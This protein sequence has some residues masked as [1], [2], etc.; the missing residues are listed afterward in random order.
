MG[1]LTTCTAS[2]MAGG[3]DLRATSETATTRA[4]WEI[5]NRCKR[6]DANIVR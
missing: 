4:A 5:N 3:H 1:L 2:L 6:D